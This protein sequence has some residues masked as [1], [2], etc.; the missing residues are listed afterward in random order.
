MHE[1]YLAIASIQYRTRKTV[2]SL[3]LQ[4]LASPAIE[5]AIEA[6]F[7]EEM[8]RLGYG[9]PEGELHKT[10]ELLWIYTG[11][12]G[13]N[14]VLYSRFTSEDT[15]YF[16]AKIDEMLAFFKTRNTDFGWT[17]GPSTQPAELAPMLETHGFVYSDSTTGLAIDLQT[18]NANIHVNPDLTITEIEDLEMLKILRSIEIS[19][20]GASEIAA[21]N[22]YDSYIHTGFG[23]GMPWHHYIGWLYE[24]PVAITSL[25]FH[26]GVAGIYGVA[27]IPT[28]RRQGVGATITLHVLYEAR[29]YGYR[30]AVLS[31]TEMSIAIYRRIGFQ[32]YCKLHHYEW[33]QGK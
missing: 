33:S 6:N 9:L 22:Y 28:A 20:F 29:R 26:A 32:E 1:K 27:T 14:A 11:S 8:A 30:I 24:E 23:N 31:P 7:S 5:E 10:P 15:P 4:S 3:I 12:H 16:Y 2:M 18:L 19:G 25:L 17:I 13:P 21:Q